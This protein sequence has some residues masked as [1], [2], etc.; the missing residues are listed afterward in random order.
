M[1]HEVPDFSNV[2]VFFRQAREH[3]KALGGSPTS[4]SKNT[5]SRLWMLSQKERLMSRLAAHWQFLRRC[6]LYNVQPSH[7]TERGMQMTFTCAIIADE[8]RAL[9]VP[10]AHELKAFIESCGFSCTSEVTD[11]VMSFEMR[12]LEV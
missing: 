1:E 11:S 4:S 12:L 5:V 6:K 2:A 3:F 9:R 8:I 7:L 10:L